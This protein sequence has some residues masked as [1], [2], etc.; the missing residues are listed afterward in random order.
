[1]LLHVTGENLGECFTRFKLNIHNPP[2]T[3]RSLGS[4]GS[5]LKFRWLLHWESL[6]VDLGVPQLVIG[7]LGT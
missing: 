7:L 4:L 5:L 2:V 3:S 1:M 6:D